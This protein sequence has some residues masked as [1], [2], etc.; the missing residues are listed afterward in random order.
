MTFWES[1]CHETCIHPTSFLPIPLLPRES[2]PNPWAYNL[3]PLSS[4]SSVFPTHLPTLTLCSKS[5]LHLLIPK[6]TQHF[7]S[8]LIFTYDVFSVWNGSTSL[9]QTTPVS[10]SGNHFPSWSP[11]QV[12]PL[13][14][15]HHQQYQIIPSLFF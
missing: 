12:Q 11:A 2:G 1:R 3:R 7:P 13:P 8:S 14:C 6:H 10:S 15:C 4:S 9:S 5:H